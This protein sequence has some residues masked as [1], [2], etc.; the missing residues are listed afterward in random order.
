MILLQSSSVWMSVDRRRIFYAVAILNGK[1]IE[2]YAAFNAAEVVGW[3]RALYAFAVGI[4]A[5]CC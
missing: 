1:I 3:C 2:T 5:P 4:D